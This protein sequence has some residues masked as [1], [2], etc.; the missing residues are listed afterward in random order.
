MDRLLR[1]PPDRVYDHLRTRVIVV[2]DG[3]MLLLPPAAGD[4]AWLPPGGGLERG[5]SLAEGAAREVWEETGVRV[6]IRGVA[7]LQEW[8]S[9][10]DRAAGQDYDLHVFFYAEA[11]GDTMP[12]A[13]APGLPLPRWVPLHEVPEL[14]L[15]PA[16]LKALALRLADGG[17]PERGA[18]TV[19]GRFEAPDGPPRALE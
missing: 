14:P 4:G 12:R 17:A 2:R 13:E 19:R 10:A 9:V 5:E 7:F 16:E 3:A 8:V 15:H 18:P 6:R 11:V 1:R